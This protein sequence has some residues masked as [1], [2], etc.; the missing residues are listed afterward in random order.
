[1][2]DYGLNSDRSRT[3]DWLKVQELAF[4]DDVESVKELEK[5][6]LKTQRASVR[7]PVIAKAV[8]RCA[9]KEVKYGEENTLFTAEKGQT[10]ICDIVCL[11]VLGFFSPFPISGLT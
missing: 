4:S 8:E 2:Y 1:L 11:L 5:L 9:V 6:V 3:C 7:L 10:V